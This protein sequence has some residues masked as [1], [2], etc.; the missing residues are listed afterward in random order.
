[1]TSSVDAKNRNLIVGVMQLTSIDSE[2]ENLDAILRL[3]NNHKAAGIIFLPENSLFLRINQDSSILPM[4]LNSE[5]LLRLQH[6]VNERAVCLHIGAT[7]IRESN[8]T[9]NASVFLEPG[10]LP[11]ITYRKIHLFDIEL[12]GQK[13]IRESDFFCR[14]REIQVLNFGPWKIGQSIC[15]D[16][17][18]AE[19]YREYSKAQCNILAVPSA[20][21]V[22]TGEAHWEPL[23]RARAI[24]N[25]AY[26]IAA[27]QGGTHISLTDAD[28]KRTTYGHSLVVD[29]WGRILYQSKS[30]GVDYFEVV[31]TLDAVESVRA[32][33][34]MHN[35]RIL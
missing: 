29:P 27:A 30:D 33:M 5:A 3:L 35:H 31:I 14:G 1:M 8:G 24:E 20:F 9:V 17:R 7:P 11:K 34:P 18:F 16:L 21:L 15:Y 13:P 32:Q 10:N 22:P 6:W 12:K 4:D 25:Q 23:L 28:L 26:V 2:S 19:L